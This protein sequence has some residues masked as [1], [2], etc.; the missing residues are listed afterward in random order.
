VKS[1]L[2]CIALAAALQTQTARAEG[3]LLGADG[4]AEAIVS[5]TSPIWTGPRTPAPVEVARPRSA[6][7]T[8]RSPRALVSVHADP[9]VDRDTMQRTMTALE[10]ARGRLS[11]LG[12]PIPFSDG[13]LGGDAGVDLYLTSELAPGAYVD[14]LVPWSYLD[15]ASTFVVM[16]PATP[17]EW[18]DACV[19][20]AYADG[21]LLGADPAESAAWRRATAAWLAW[22]LTGRFGCDDAVHEQQAEP[23]RSWI[24]NGADGGA[25][26]AMLLAYLSARHADGSPEFVRDVWDLARQRTW[27]GVG[28]RAE[29]DVWSAFDAAIGL[30]GDS[31]LDNVVDLGVARWFIGRTAD[32]DPALRGLDADATAPVTRTMT[33]L[34]T[35]VSAPVPLE[36][37]GSGYVVMG[38]SVW[39]DLRRLRAWFRGEYGVRWSFAA[40]QVDETGHELGR[41]VAPSTSVTPEAFLPIQLDDD[42]AQLVFVVTHLGNDLLDA[43]EPITTERSFE[44]VVDRAD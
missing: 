13:D 20:E 9:S 35:R 32:V 33:R 39:G 6:S 3:D 8:M 24:A 27:E 14:E 10:S 29:P 4:I 38:R 44:I 11:A 41:M 18:V 21:V 26:G 42:T 22:E 5:M 31:L 37:G 23:F 1:I 7:S 40:V 25:G 16:D 43:D 34:P 15:G 12:W 17:S 28:L 30:S 2:V 36:P 19:I